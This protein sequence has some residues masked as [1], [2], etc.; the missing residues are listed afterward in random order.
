MDWKTLL[1]EN[2]RGKRSHPYRTQTAVITFLAKRKAMCGVPF[3][4][5]EGIARIF[6]RF[7]GIC[8]VC[9]KGILRRIKYIIPAISDSH[10]IAVDRGIDSTGFKITIRGDYL[11]TK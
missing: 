11:G 5:L 8:S 7:T 10:G 9:Y 3:R 2:N 4:S 6:F 1:E